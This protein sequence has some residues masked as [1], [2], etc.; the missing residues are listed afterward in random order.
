MGRFEF[1]GFLR[2]ER[3]IVKKD[4]SMK[5]LIWNKKDFG[6]NIFLDLILTVKFSELF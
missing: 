2:K 1:Q 4:Y 3:V 5:M 6:L